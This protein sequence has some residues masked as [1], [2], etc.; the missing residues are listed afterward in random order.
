MDDQLG[1]AKPFIA[2]Y[3]NSP[4]AT[5]ILDRTLE[6][7]WENKAA[8]SGDSL[9]RQLNWD[10]CLIRA[11]QNGLLTCLHQGKPFTL[12]NPLLAFL[13]LPQSVPAPQNHRHLHFD[14]IT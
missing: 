6:I 1:W 8:K 3:A 12:A 4:I 5:L 13:F 14:L 2:M 9:I 10:D 7:Q 11:K